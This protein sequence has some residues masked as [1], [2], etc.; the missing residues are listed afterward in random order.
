MSGLREATYLLGGV[1][2]GLGSALTSLLASRG[3][4]VCACARSS[5]TLL[6]LASEAQNRGWRVETFSGDLSRQ[7][8]VDRWM[9]EVRLHHPRLEGGAIL[10]GRWVAGG[11]LL[12]EARDEDWEHGLA[13][14]LEPVFR[15]GRALLRTFVDQRQGSLVL[16]SATERIG[17]SGHPAYCV[18]KAGVAE[19]ARKLAHDY[20]RY[21]VR[22]NAVLAGTME[23][24]LPSLD[25]PD[26][27]SPVDLR[28]ASGVGSWEVARMVAYLLAPEGRWVSGAVIPV[29]GG[30]STGGKPPEVLTGTG[31]TPSFRSP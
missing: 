22:V 19:L 30:N 6:R 16:V 12:H 11:P 3:A 29:D 17:R 26:L 8:D 24:D 31:P 10:A 23:H 28:D 9:G 7:E 13:E 15:M 1:G 18:A 14:N 21:N 20:R 2:S 4:T 5:S 25:P 27:S